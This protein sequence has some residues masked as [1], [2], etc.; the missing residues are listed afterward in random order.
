MK[1]EFIETHSGEFPV[2]RICQ[3]LDVSKSGYYSWVKCPRSK[4][5]FEDEIILESIKS[6]HIASDKRYEAPPKK[7][8]RS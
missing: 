5:S 8:T 3:T 4:R 2:S 7:W 6:S 1:Y